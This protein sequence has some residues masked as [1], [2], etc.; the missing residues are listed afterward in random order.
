[1]ARYMTPTPEQEAANAAHVAAQPPQIRAIMERLSPFELYRIKSTGCRCAIQSVDDDGTVAVGVLR[2]F[3]PDRPD[4]DV[5]ELVFG[6]EPD[7]LEP[8]KLPDGIG[9]ETRH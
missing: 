3:N 6:L 8:C 9:L 5:D 7:D 4:V 1:M 2:E